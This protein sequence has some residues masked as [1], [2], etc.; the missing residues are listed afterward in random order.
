MAQEQAR[1][2]RCA[3]GRPAKRRYAGPRPFDQA[4]VPDAVADSA[5][6]RAAAEEA[7]ALSV[8]CPKGFGVLEAC[9]GNALREQARRSVSTDRLAA[10]EARTVRAAA[11]ACQRWWSWRDTAGVP[12][13]DEF[14]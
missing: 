11:A 3:Y 1:G 14:P 7:V 8:S 2:A 6:L 9:G 13:F 5:R 10:F 12:I 4:A